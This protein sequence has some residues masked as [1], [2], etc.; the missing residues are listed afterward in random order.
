MAPANLAFFLIL[1]AR[2][3]FALGHFAFEQPRLEHVHRGG[4][5]LVLAAIV[6]AGDDD[7]GGLVS[8]V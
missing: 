6:L 7:A 3:R 5:V 4:A 1:A 2:S 8:D